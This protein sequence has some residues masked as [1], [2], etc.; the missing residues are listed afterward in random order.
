MLVERFDTQALKW[1]MSNDKMA[2]TFFLA[3]KSMGWFYSTALPTGLGLEK[4]KG[5]KY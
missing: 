4:K 2:W 3:P 5:I 1:Q